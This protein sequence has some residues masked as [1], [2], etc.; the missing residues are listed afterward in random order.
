MSKTKT[1]FGKREGFLFGAMIL[2]AIGIMVVFVFGSKKK[3][4]E[5]GELVYLVVQNVRA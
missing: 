2:V 3:K 4:E 5:E 1:G